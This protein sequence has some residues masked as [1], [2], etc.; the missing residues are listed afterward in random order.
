MLLG[1]ARSAHPRPGFGPRSR[2]QRRHILRSRVV[3]VVLDYWWVVVFTIVFG[4]FGARG[5]REDSV[6]GLR[7]SSVHHREVGVSR[8]DLRRAQGPTARTWPLRLLPVWQCHCHEDGPPGHV[9]ACTGMST[10]NRRRR[11]NGLTVFDCTQALGL[12]EAVPATHDCVG[13]AQSDAVQPAQ[14]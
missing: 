6:C 14:Q 9:T 13:G 2:R 8:S 4:G 5:P 7:Y 11:C 10:A 12:L 3:C 1:D